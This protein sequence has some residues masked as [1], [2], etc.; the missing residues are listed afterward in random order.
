MLVAGALGRA[1]VVLIAIGSLRFWGV[2]LRVVRLQRVAFTMVMSA[3]ALAWAM[4]NVFWWA[5]WPF[6]RVVPWWIAF[7]ALTIVGERL[8]LS[9]FQKPSKWSAPLLYSAL[10]LFTGGVVLASAWQIPGERL[11]G[12]GLLALT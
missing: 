1:P 4:G 5:G 6:N 9:R 2:T 7:L 3:G 8:D 12:V 11:T 10:G